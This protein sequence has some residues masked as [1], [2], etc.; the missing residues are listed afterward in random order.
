MTERDHQIFA[1]ELR[2]LRTS[3]GFETGKEFAAHIGW[4]ASKVS[5][6]ENARTV[7]A[8]ADLDVWL[9]AVGADEETE[10]RLRGALVDLRL[11]R[12][13]WKQ[14]LRRG[15]SE[16]QHVEAVA[17]RDATFI[18]SVELFLIPGLVQT[19][20]YARLVFEMAAEMHDT[21]TDTDEAVRERIRRQDVLYDPSKRIEIL[22]GES[23][24]R[25][26][27]C[28]VPMLR[29]QI[30]RLLNLVG[31]AHVRLG[32]VPLDS[33][34]PTI[35]MHGY[36][37]HDDTVLVEVNHTEITVTEP[38]DVALYVGI[39]E[40]LWEIAVEGDEARDLLQRVLRA[41]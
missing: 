20:G 39:T 40:K 26:P 19:P 30:D 17:E 11:A 9:P 21:P 28:D 16:R 31:L 36:T 4:V 24:L 25:Y 38:T 6:I 15:H 12:D 33:K 7:P 3:A 2:R 35:T 23:A 32:I 29:V 27:I 1:S 13:R 8:D 22:I 18:A 41:L 10:A 14:Q 34:L 5:R 37:V